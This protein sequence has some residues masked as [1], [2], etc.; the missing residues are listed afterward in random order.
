MWNL[1]YTDEDEKSETIVYSY[2]A[3]EKIVIGFEKKTFN[4]CYSL[5]WFYMECIIPF[6]LVQLKTK[7]NYKHRN[8]CT[9][10]DISR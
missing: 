9:Q 10:C 4:K 8:V 3:M 7:I 5:C 6:H 1:H 2:Q